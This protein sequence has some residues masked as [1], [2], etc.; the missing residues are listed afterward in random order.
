M[1]RKAG[2]DGKGGK[3]VGVLGYWVGDGVKYQQMQLEK[4]TR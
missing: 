3:G 4:K 1:E 2:A